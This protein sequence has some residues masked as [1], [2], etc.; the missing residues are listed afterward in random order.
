[1]SARSKVALEA[2]IRNFAAYFQRHPD[3]N[4]ADIAYT[5]QAGRRAFA[6]RFFL[7]CSNASDAASALAQLSTAR[8]NF[9][10]TLLGTRPPGTRSLAFLFTG[11]GSQRENM[12][13]EIYKTEPAFRS[14][15][16]ECS[17]LL[18]EQVGFDLR[19][20]LYPAHKTHAGA[21][22][23]LDQA[24]VAELA[25]FVFEYALA[26]LWMKWG[27]HPNVMIAQS[28]GEFVA[29]CLA[30]VFSLAD[31]L[32]LLAER[33][34]L[35]KG[36]PEG[37]I[38][39]PVPALRSV[40]ARLRLHPPQIPFVSNATGTWITAASATDPEYWSAHSARAMLF[41]Q[42]ME[43]ILK[44]SERT[45]LVVGPGRALSGIAQPVPD[46]LCDQS[47]ITSLVDSCEHVPDMESLLTALGRLWL[48][49]SEVDW[50]GFWGHEK[51]RRVP[52][53]TYA[54]ERKRYWVDPQPRTDATQ[55]RVTHVS[56]DTRSG[57]TSPQCAAVPESRSGSGACFR[58]SSALAT[59]HVERVVAEIWQELL[60][61]DHVGIY[62]NFFQ[63]GG[64]SMQGAQL[65]SR[66]R[67]ALDVEVP[68]PSL[69]EAPT[70]AGMAE[71]IRAF[72]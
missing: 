67:S 48:E 62:D 45:V 63:L 8:I 47:V 4:L 28:I 27:I 37:A 10:H 15:V 35:L 57:A 9:Q 2:A 44:T 54:F 69:F 55:N 56:E 39:E 33:S 72:R 46:Y 14:C 68:L 71:R 53:P 18:K 26:R 34:R 13:S 20:V 5:C 21:T 49:G 41:A 16:D 64:H 43:C 58:D 19:D 38:L 65:V 17:E 1:M 11:Q 32:S 7:V 6:R 40:A 52:L 66:L 61:I 31:A 70:V 59:D 12:G 25:L 23:H 22:P 29:A 60:G 30:G 50:P 36:M 3:A 24:E 42:G 51:R